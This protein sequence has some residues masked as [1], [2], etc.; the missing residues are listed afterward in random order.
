MTTELIQP[1][2]HL[3][4]NERNPFLHLPAE[5]HSMIA[6]GLDLLELVRFSRKTAKAIKINFHLMVFQMTQ[7]A[8]NSV[9]N[10]C[11]VSLNADLRNLQKFLGKD[12][13]GI[14]KMITSL[15]VESIYNS[16]HS[17]PTHDQ[18]L[19]H[20]PNLTDLSIIWQNRGWGDQVQF[21][22]YL[23]KL[24]KIR[25]ITYHY[26]GPI[27]SFLKACVVH[28]STS[29]TDVDFSFCSAKTEHLFEPLQAQKSLTRLN[30]T[31]GS[32]TEAPDISMYACL[33]E[34]ILNNNPITSL[35][36]LGFS[37]SLETLD[38]SWAKIEELP[39][40]EL[41]PKL[42][43]LILFVCNKLTT[44]SVRNMRSKTLQRLNLER[45]EITQLPHLPNLPALL[46][47]NVRSVTTLAKDA[48]CNLVSNSLQTLILSHTDVPYP[49]PENITSKVTVPDLSRLTALRELDLSE[50]QITSEDAYVHLA[51]DT[52][53]TL[54]LRGVWKNKS[55]NLN[56][57]SKIQKLILREAFLCELMKN[58]P[59]MR[60]PSL[61]VI[62][63][64]LGCSVRVEESYFKVSLLTFFPNLKQ[65]QLISDGS[66]TRYGREDYED[67]YVNV[68]RGINPGVDIHLRKQ[69]WQS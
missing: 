21:P 4:L 3:S 10:R 61:H 59:Q 37:A 60:V 32:I 68:I 48:L 18:F 26:Q 57:L 27:L 40:L 34:L 29:L 62:E 12:F 51:S 30:L 54:N 42:R 22:A 46:E 55:F 43:T 6:G 36:T 11:V 53:E 45:T 23:P 35:H 64:T 65:L 28:K 7:Q 9:M 58:N 8:R 16:N 17:L 41:F 20:F 33:S 15:N 67:R 52:L 24:R 2:A 49:N 66:M 25:L 44:A 56:R 69:N 50:N 47:L 13:E 5:I 38:V 14:C 1:M 31:G 63:T 19:E 39:D